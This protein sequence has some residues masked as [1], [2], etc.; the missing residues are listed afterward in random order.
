MSRKKT[1]RITKQKVNR[2]KEQTN[3]PTFDATKDNHQ[4]KGINIERAL[5]N[6]ALV[7]L[8]IAKDT[9]PAAP[10]DHNANGS[11][12]SRKGGPQ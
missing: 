7:L 10:D 3:T 8:D 2:G 4:I 11:L 5:W 1:D 9:Q 6:L 12:I